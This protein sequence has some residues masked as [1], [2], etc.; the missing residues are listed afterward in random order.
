MKPLVAV[1]FFALYL[2]ICVIVTRLRAEF[3]LPVH[4]MHH[5]APD[6]TMVRLT[7]D[8]I[9]DRQTLGAFSVFYWFNRVYRSHPMPHQLEGMKLAGSDGRA[10]RQMFAA[11]LIAGMSAVPVCFLIYLN[12]FY[13]WGAAT[14]HINQWG[15]AYGREM[16]VKLEGYLRPGIPPQYGEK[17]ATVFGFGVALLLSALRMRSVGFPFTP[18]GLCCSVRM[19]DAEPLAAHHDWQLVQNGRAARWRVCR[20]PQGRNA[21]FRSDARGV[22]DR[23][24]LDGLRSA[25]PRANI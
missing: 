20:L 23:M 16:C 25:V 19:G 22:R 12:G 15:T 9:F 5:A 14:A 21:V 6:W 1:V 10:Q 3:G 13:H 2:V 18:A 8:D 7:G 24:Q 11:I 17:V 4:T